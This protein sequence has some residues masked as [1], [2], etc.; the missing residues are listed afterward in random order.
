MRVTVPA[1]FWMKNNLLRNYRRLKALLAMDVKPIA[2]VP[3]GAFAV[4]IGA[5]AF[6][7]VFAFAYLDPVMPRPGTG[8]THEIRVAFWSLTEI[9]RSTWTLVPTG[10]L[11]IGAILIDWRNL[12]RHRQY[13]LTRLVGFSMLAFLSVAG[14]GLAIMALKQIIGRARPWY[15]ETLGPYN[16]KPFQ[17]TSDFGSFP[18]GHSASAG[19]LAM[20]L[21]IAFPALRIPALGVGAAV[22]ASRYMGG[23]HYPADV[24]AGLLLGIGFCWLVSRWLV[25]RNLAE[26]P[27]AHKLRA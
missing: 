7:V 12:A 13:W 24:I 26:F 3:G 1:V 6:L 16:F 2:V 9:G 20:A 17:F 14:S 15:Y 10:A 23:V 22:A 25:R 11:L 21:A 18:S 27:F 5:F 19:A 4:A 8:F